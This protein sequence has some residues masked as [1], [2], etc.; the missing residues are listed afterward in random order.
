MVLFF[1]FVKHTGHDPQEE[2]TK[3]GCRSE[4][5]VVNFN[6]IAILF[7]LLELMVL[8]KEKKRKTYCLNM[9]I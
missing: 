6:K 3:F 1:N 9:T 5:K 2:I 8:K 7:W 4:E